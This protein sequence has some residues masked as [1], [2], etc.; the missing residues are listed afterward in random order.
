[1]E[2]KNPNSDKVMGSSGNAEKT[3]A[4][5]MAPILEYLLRLASGVTKITTY[6]VPRT[7]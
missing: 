5:V 2:K 6:N 7:L 3:T 1:M 4:A